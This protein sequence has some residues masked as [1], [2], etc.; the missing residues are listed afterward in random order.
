MQKFACATAG[1]AFVPL[2]Y[3]GIYG[4]YQL[5]NTLSIP[6][7]L[8]IPIQAGATI[9]FFGTSCFFGLAA[10]KAIVE[11][12]D[13]LRSETKCCMMIRDIFMN[14]NLLLWSTFLMLVSAVLTFLLAASIRDRW[15]PKRENRW[16]QF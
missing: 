11:M 9:I 5:F 3:G 12:I 8:D 16:L 1:L 10:S 6:T 4:G 14:I 2:A 13:T 7:Y 15:I